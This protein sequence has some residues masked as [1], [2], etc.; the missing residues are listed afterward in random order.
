MFEIFE[1]VIVYLIKMRCKFLPVVVVLLYIMKQLKCFLISWFSFVF[2]YN[3]CSSSFTFNS[4]SLRST[5]C[6]DVSASSFVFNK[7]SLSSF[8][9]FSL[10]ISFSF[11]QAPID[12]QYSAVFVS[13]RTLIFGCSVFFFGIC[14]QYIFLR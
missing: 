7:I 13:F 10:M 2:L 1:E 8:S 11:F 5:K 3:F 4:A 14:L 9:F 6:I 12:I